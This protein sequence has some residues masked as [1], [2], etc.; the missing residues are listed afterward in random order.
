MGVIKWINNLSGGVNQYSDPGLI[1]PNQFELL[2]NVSQEQLGSIST[3][4]GTTLYNDLIAGSGQVQG[5]DTYYK[6]DGTYYFHAFMG[7]NLRVGNESTN[8]WDLQESSVVGASSTVEFTNFLNRHYFIG[9]ENTEYLRYATDAGNS[10]TVKIL[11][12]TADSSSTGTTLVLSTGLFQEGMVGMTI[13]NE[14]DGTSA[15]ITAYTSTTTVTLDTTINDSWDGDD[16]AIYMEGKYLASNGAYML[17]AGNDNRRAYWV[18]ALSESTGL[19][20]VDTDADFYETVAPHTGCISF[21]F[22]RPFILFTET[23]I[24]II[25]PARKYFDEIPGNFGCS[26]HRGAQIIR[27]NLI[28]PSR[29]GKGF[30]MMGPNDSAPQIISLPVQNN[31]TLDAVINKISGSAWSTMAAGIKE[32]TYLCYVGNLTGEVHGETIDDCIL[33]YNVMQQSWKVREYSRNGI[34]SVFCNFI[35]EN[36]NADLYG[37]SKDNYAIYKME[38]YGTYTDDNSSGEGADISSVIVSAPLEFNES[39]RGTVDEKRIEKFHI[40][41]RSANVITPAAAL[42]GAEAYSTDGLDDFEAKDTNRWYWDY[43]DYGQDAKSVGFKLSTSGE[44]TIFDYGPEISS[45]DSTGLKGE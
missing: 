22:G 28:Y 3:R 15:V 21:G 25:D 5:M 30:Y 35:D 44:F 37:A 29:V 24:V 33:E 2:L 9:S 45:T 20:F 32:N 41:Y 36:G 23:S 1:S 14:T 4:P 12:T 42:D 10:V 18:N 7:G 16:I 26:S 13:H 43:N 31:V 19:P 39:S 27:G 11:D 6:S 8:T 40:K 34:G 38:V 17:V